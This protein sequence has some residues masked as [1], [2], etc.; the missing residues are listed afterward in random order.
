MFAASVSFWASYL[1]V[2]RVLFEPLGREE[3]EVEV[4][5]VGSRTAAMMVVEG[6]AR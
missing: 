4:E 5:F 6:R 1:T 2:M 3:R